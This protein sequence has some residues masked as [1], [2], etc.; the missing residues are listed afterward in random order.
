MRLHRIVIVSVGVLMLSGVV[1]T[2][3]RNTPE[4]RLRA[5]MDKETVD[6]DLKAAIDGYKQ[7]ISQRGASR[8]VVAQALLRLGMAY[9]KQGDAE[10]RKLYEQLVRGYGDQTAVVQQARARLATSSGTA[11]TTMRLVCT[12]D[13]GGALSPDGRFLS[14]RTSDGG[15]AVQELRGGASRQILPPPTSGRVFGGHISPDGR[16][17]AYEYPGSGVVVGNSD[18][19]GRRTIFSR[20]EGFY[21]PAPLAWSPD[22]LRL[23]IAA[24]SGSGPTDPGRFSWLNAVDGAI[25]QTLAPVHRL[26]WEA[27]VSPDGKFIAFNAYEQPDSVLRADVFVMASDGSGEVRVSEKAAFNFPVGWSPDGRFVFFAQAGDDSLWKVPMAAGKVQGA[28]VAVTV[29]HR[30]QVDGYLGVIAGTLYY[31]VT[32]ATSDVYTASMDPVS[33]LVTSPPA[34]VPTLR[35]GSNMSLR[36]SPDSRRLLYQSAGPTF[37]QNVPQELRMITLD[38]GKDQR[39]A[40]KVYGGPR[41]CWAPDGRSILVNTVTEAPPVRQEPARVDLATGETRILFPGAPTFRIRS[42]SDSLMAAYQ[43]G[44]IVVRNIQTGADTEVYRLR[45]NVL[46]VPNV[47]WGVPKLSHDGRTVLFVESLDE[48][49]SAL[50]TV[51]STGGSARA[52]VRV[53]TPAQLQPQIGFTWSPD[54][55]FVYFVR[56]ANATAPHELF[57]V[58]ASGGAEERVGLA[59]ADIR[60]LDISPDGRRIAFSL[61]AVGRQEIWAMDNF[62]PSGR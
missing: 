29:P 5:A 25:Q 31:R 14:R 47:T 26:F 62:L 53:K 17:I 55:R 9:E 35:N 43:A 22:G 59:G 20:R 36:W 28:A 42:C 61:G 60:D 18:G 4:A 8:E 12:A 54:D 19:T 37:V 2:Q 11:A 52:L 56:R 46:N 49:T 6:G 1:A 44:A 21:S 15:W 33:G 50:M 41:A 7:V 34:L 23:L 48:T 24:W 51:P 3:G 30:G 57:R 38:D 27:K 58:P 16:R 13:C 39:V 40:D 10:A 32:A 45:R